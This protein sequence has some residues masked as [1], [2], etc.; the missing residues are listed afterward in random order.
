MDYVSMNKAIEKMNKIS[1]KF[2]TI[3]GLRRKANDLIEAHLPQM[4]SGGGGGGDVRYIEPAL[5]ISIKDLLTEASSLELGPDYDRLLMNGAPIMEL[6]YIGQFG[7]IKIRPVP[8][9]D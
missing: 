2:D 6:S 4:W 7:T 1:A 5:Y 3:Q 9:N 8:Y